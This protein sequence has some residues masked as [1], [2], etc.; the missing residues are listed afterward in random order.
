MFGGGPSDD[1]EQDAALRRQVVGRWGRSDSDL[2]Y[3]DFA[4]GGGLRGAD[5][6]SDPVA[7]AR[8]E[9]PFAAAEY[10]G[11]WEINNGYLRLHKPNHDIVI[12]L[13][14]TDDGRLQLYDSIERIEHAW[15]YHRL[16]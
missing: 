2:V 7:V 12:R 10:V 14:F 6:T 3:F 4:A 5:M 1:P 13:R 16:P 11:R 9:E 15:V 8:G